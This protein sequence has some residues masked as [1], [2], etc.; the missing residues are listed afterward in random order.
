MKKQ[1]AE[2]EEAA[3]RRRFDRREGTGEAQK[4]EAS[5]G[6]ILVPSASSEFT[7]STAD[8]DINGP[9]S[10]LFKIINWHARFQHV[11]G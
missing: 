1:K 11:S 7:G 2:E 8:G 3:R 5:R 9:L 10:R 6:A 4:K